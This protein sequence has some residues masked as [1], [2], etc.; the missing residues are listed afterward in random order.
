M[1]DPTVR[2]IFILSGTNYSLKVEKGL[3]KENILFTLDKTCS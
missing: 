2:P 3:T 1:G